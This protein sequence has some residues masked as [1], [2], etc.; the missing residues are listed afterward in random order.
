MLGE[1]MLYGYRDTQRREES[2]PRDPL[3][4]EPHAFD[5]SSDGIL[6]QLRNLFPARAL[7]RPGLHLPF[8]SIR[9]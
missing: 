5:R 6:L 7:P 2:R 9:K 4:A 1:G 8:L 3:F